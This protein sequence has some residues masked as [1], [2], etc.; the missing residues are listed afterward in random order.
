[1]V[2]SAVLKNPELAREIVNRGHEAAGH[3]MNWATQ[4]TMNYE[5]EKKFIKD[6]ADAIKKVTGFVVKGYNANWLRRGENT[7]K[8]LQ[9]QG[10][11]YH[12][13]HISR[14][15]NAGRCLLVFTT[16]LVGHPK[17]S[18]LL[19]KLSHT[20]SN[21][22]ALTFKRKDEIAVITLKDPNALREN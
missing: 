20:F 16:G 21:M 13:D 12:I 11:T 4:Y 17:W 22:R 1:M 5:E 9:E 10:F 7:L 19:P 8:I 15:P 3:G 6:G 2:G 14:R 18:M